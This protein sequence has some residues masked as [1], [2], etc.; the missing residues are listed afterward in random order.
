MTPEAKRLQRALI[1]YSRVFRQ[2]DDNVWCVQAIVSLIRVVA[3]LNEGGSCQFT[4]TSTDTEI[5]VDVK[6]RR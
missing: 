2:V 5:N 3:G 4:R 6:S 1:L